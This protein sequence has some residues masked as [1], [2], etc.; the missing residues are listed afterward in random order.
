[1]GG[2][3]EHLGDQ[4][5]RPSTSKYPRPVSNYAAVIPQETV[6]IRE[7]CGDCLAG[8]ERCGQR[9]GAS[10]RRAAYANSEVVATVAR[11][12]AIT[13]SEIPAQK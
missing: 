4:C 12:P 10:R 9:L 2:V 13:I 5:S 11:Y 7:A 8:S 6:N 3:N 1:M